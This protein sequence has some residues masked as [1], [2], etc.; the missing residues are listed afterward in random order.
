MNDRLHTLNDMDRLEVAH[1]FLCDPSELSAKLPVGKSD[2]TIITQ[3]INSIYC[4]FNDFLVTL[5]H[6]TFDIDIIVLTECRLNANK[7]LPHLQNYISYYTGNQLNQNDGV[8]IYIRNNLKHNVKQIDLTHASCLQVDVLDTIV[9]GIYRS[10]SNKNAEPFINSLSSHL[11]SANWRGR[12]VVTGDINI[13][14]RLREAETS[15]NRKNRSSYLNMLASFGILAGHSQIT[16]D[17]TSLDHMMLKINKK[18]ETATVAILET[19]T[20]DHKSVLLCISKIKIGPQPKKNKT[21]IDFEMPY[22]I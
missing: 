19:S 9:L 4:N 8:V 14:I 11:S 17:T 18:K 2:F 6:F 13:N 10:P 21:K 15:Q 20:T 3:N 5:A 12:V 7:P 16:R 1:F 22:Y